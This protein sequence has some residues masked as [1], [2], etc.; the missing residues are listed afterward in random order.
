[1][2]KSALKKL[3]N[4]PKV[5]AALEIVRDDNSISGDTKEVLDRWFTDI[6]GLFSGLH[7]DSELAF[8]DSFYNEVLNKI[9]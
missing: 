9:S 5:K 1:M 4:P 2:Q 7:A 8:S 6:S 3:D